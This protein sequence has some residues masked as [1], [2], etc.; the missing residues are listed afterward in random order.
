MGNRSRKETVIEKSIPESP[1]ENANNIPLIIEPTTVTNGM[2][3]NGNL[4][5]EDEEEVEEAEEA[6]EE[7]K[8]TTFISETIDI[9]D[10]LCKGSHFVTFD[11]P[12][13]YEEEDRDS[14]T[15]SGDFSNAKPISDLLAEEEQPWWNDPQQVAQSKPKVD[16]SN[17]KKSSALD[18]RPWWEVGKESSA[19]PLE[20]QNQ[21]D[22]AV[23]EEANGNVDEDGEESEWESEY[24]EE[25]EEGE[26]EYYYDEDEA[27]EDVSETLDAATQRRT[28]ESDMDERKEWIIQ[29]L[30]QIIPKMPT[31]VQEPIEEEN[32]E[33][34]DNVFD[35]REEDELKIKQM[36]EPDQKGY[37]DWLEEAALDLKENGTAS[38]E[39]MS[40]VSEETPSIEETVIELTEEEKKTRAKANKIVD[41]LKNTEGSDLKK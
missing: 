8:P 13:A 34:D 4:E 23:E 22:M 14:K 28:T 15:N 18:E 2:M 20:E 19:D 16:F 26:W 1:L 37:K 5:D 31:R 11:S 27:E 7:E 35:E 32:S 9:D 12:V 41:K 36:T 30:Q 25:E 39:I 17:C 38:L 40:P 29:G 6:D 33:G 3:P 24:E 10:L 21:T